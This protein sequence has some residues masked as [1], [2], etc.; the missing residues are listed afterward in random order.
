[1]LQKLLDL[2]YWRFK[3]WN[4]RCFACTKKQTY[5]DGKV[6][7][8]IAFQHPKRYYHERCLNNVMGHAT[9]NFK[10]QT[11]RQETF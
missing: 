10:K 1:M 5:E 11:T 2:T 3:R 6:N 7:F 9:P 4:R 8:G